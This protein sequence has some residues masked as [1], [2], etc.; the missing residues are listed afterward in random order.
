MA[1]QTLA[2]GDRYHARRI[3]LSAVDVVV[4]ALSLATD[5]ITALLSIKA[6]LHVRVGAQNS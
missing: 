2:A 3:A 4:A 6:A 1:A 5:V